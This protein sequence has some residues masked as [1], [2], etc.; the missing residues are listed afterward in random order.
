MGVA[1]TCISEICEKEHELKAFG[2]LNGMWGLGKRERERQRE[3]ERERKLTLTLIKINCEN[4]HRNGIIACV[5]QSHHCHV[6]DAGILY[7]E[8]LSL[9]HSYYH[10]LHIHSPSSGVLRV[11]ALSAGLIVGPAVG[12]FLSRPAIQYPS[13]V[14]ST[15]IWGVFPYLLPCLGEQHCTAL[16]SCT[17]MLLHLHLQSCFSNSAILHS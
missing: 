15:S 4:T 17:V 10:I 3:R 8:R 11:P 16:H 2:M 6:C 5:Q 7:F 9:S 13:I 1:K 12:G 14:P